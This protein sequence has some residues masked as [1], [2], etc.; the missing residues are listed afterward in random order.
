MLLGEVLHLQINSHLLGKKKKTRLEK[1]SS[2]PLSKVRAVSLLGNT[3]C[4]MK[5]LLGYFTK[6]E[7]PKLS[8]L[9][10]NE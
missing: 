7:I 9:G 5:L 3:S 1:F 2:F 8:T 10:F 4:L 6:V